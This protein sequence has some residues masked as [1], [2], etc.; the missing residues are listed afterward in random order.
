[1]LNP[2]LS[3]FWSLYQFWNIYMFYDIIEINKN[4]ETGVFYMEF[5]Q[6]GLFIRAQRRQRGWTQQELANRAGVTQPMV[7]RIENGNNT[8]LT[9][10]SR[11]AAAF[12]KKINITFTDTDPGGPSWKTVS[13]LFYLRLAKPLLTA[14]RPLTPPIWLNAG[15]S[16]YSSSG[17]LQIIGV[18]WRLASDF[19]RHR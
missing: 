11:I 6:V 19:G 4:N 3:T 7:A 14:L 13:N 1:M 8:R 12:D 9:T 18:P 2:N 10:L 16:S 5:P 17:P 15:Q